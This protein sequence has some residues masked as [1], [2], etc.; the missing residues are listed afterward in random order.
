MDYLVVITRTI[1]FYFLIAILYRLMGKREVGQ[2]GIID[3][4][5]SISIAQLAVISIENYKAPIFTALIPVVFLFLF[6]VVFAYISLKNQAFRNLLGGKPSIIIKNG[7]LNFKEMV[8]ER[9]NLDDLLTQLRDKGIRSIEEVEY[10]VLEENGRL[11]VFKYNLLRLPT[12]YPMPIILD[13]DIQKDTLK[14]LNKTETWLKN[15]LREENVDLKEVFYA[16]YKGRKLYIIKKSG[17][18]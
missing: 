2:L 5:V 17:L 8:K 13:G 18:L 12:N 16:F 7:K 15:M 6:Q 9:Y 11:S 14:A 4:I 3:L 1:L 10:A